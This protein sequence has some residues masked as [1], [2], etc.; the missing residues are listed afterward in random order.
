MASSQ[1]SGAQ[2]SAAA[3]VAALVVPEDGLVPATVAAQAQ[4]ARS[5][6]VADNP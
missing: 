6:F 5:P 2:N 4:A 1:C 3:R